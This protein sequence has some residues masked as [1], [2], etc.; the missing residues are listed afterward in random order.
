MSEYVALYDDDW[1]K[2]FNKYSNELKIRIVKKISKILEY[3]EKRH[4]KSGA[5]FFVDEIGQSRLLYRVFEDTKQVKFY[6]IGDHKEYEKY[7]KEFN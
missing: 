4:L 1:G 3:P 2:Y 7:Y 6:F 5:R